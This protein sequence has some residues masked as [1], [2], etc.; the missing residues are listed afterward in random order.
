MQTLQEISTIESDFPDVKVNT[1]IVFTKF[2]AREYTSMKYLGD[3]AERYKDI[4]LN[5]MIRTSAD[6]KNAITKKEDLFGYK[7]SNAR[8]DYD[9]L[10]RELMEIDL[11]VGKK[12]QRRTI[13][14]II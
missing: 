10:T 6:V 7:K 14:N 5:T 13:D 4:L 11:I 12:G 1:R 3:I 2:D 8:D 9:S